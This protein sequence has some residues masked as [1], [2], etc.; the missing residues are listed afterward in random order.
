MW[1]ARALAIS[2]C[3]SL[4]IFNYNQTVPTALSSAFFTAFV[5]SGLL[6]YLFCDICSY[7]QDGRKAILKTIERRNV[8]E[9]S[10]ENEE[11]SSVDINSNEKN[12]K[13]KVKTIDL[14]LILL[15]LSKIA[16]FPSTIVI[17]CF[18]A[19]A[20]KP[21][22]LISLDHVSQSYFFAFEIFM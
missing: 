17:F 4:A 13:S 18:Y 3:F 11:K 10:S 1:I 6:F 20:K 21:I 22:D 5:Y 2:C 12:K 16:Y 14:L 19:V 7:A 9:F 15:R 8:D